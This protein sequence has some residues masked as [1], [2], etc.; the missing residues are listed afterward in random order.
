MRG[1][2]SDNV[3]SAYPGVRTKGT[4]NKVGL[5][6]AYAERKSKGFKTFIYFSIFR[7]VHGFLVLIFI[8]YFGY[9]ANAGAATYA[10][11][12]LISAVLSRLIFKKIKKRFNL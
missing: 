10:V 5:L 6:E 1:D 12:L 11:Y 2:T 4:K 3:F 7:A 8:Y 9:K